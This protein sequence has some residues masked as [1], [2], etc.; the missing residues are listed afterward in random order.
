MFT[1]GMRLCEKRQEKKTRTIGRTHPILICMICFGVIHGRDKA[2]CEARWGSVLCVTQALCPG[3]RAESSGRA[4]WRTPGSAAASPRA[5]LS[6][7]DR[8]SSRKPSPRGGSHESHE[9]LNNRIFTSL[10]HPLRLA[11]EKET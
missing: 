10:E 11:Q 5:S 8:T 7:A 1:D 9:S 4:V 2:V 6:P 3:Q